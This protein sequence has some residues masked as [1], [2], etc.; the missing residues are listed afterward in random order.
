MNDHSDA[1]PVNENTKREGETPAPDAPKAPDAAEHAATESAAPPS[2]PSQGSAPAPEAATAPPAASSTPPAEAPP[3]QAIP[4]PESMETAVSKEV[5]TDAAAAMAGAMSGTDLGPDVDP[6]KL[7]PGQQ[8]TGTIVGVEGED[9]FLQFGPKVQGIVPRSQFGKKE[10]V[11]K[12]RRVDTTVEKYD[13]SSGLLMVARVGATQRATW[14][15][16]QPGMIVEGRVTGVVKGGLEIDLKGIRAFMPG[17][18]TDTHPMKDISVLLNENIRGEVIEVDRRGKNVILSRRKLMAKEQKEARK[19][20]KTELEVGQKRKGV[21]KRITDFGAFVDIGGIDGLLHISDLSWSMVDKV[22][23]VVKE[24]QEVEVIVLKL[25]EKKER[26]SLGL[27]QAQPSPWDDAPDKYPVGTSLKVR[28]LRLAKFGAFAELE[29]GLEGL[30]PISELSWNRV[31]TAKEVVG[32]GDMVDAVVIRCEPQKQRLALSVKQ[33]TPDPWQ[34]VLESFEPQALVKGK[35]T[36]LTDFGAFVEIAPG[37]EGLVHISEMSKDR[38]RSAGDVVK[39][40]QE[41][42]TRVLGVDAENRRISLSIKQVAEPDPEA[43]AAEAAEPHKPKKRKKP[44]R[45]GL[46]SNWEWQG[47][48]ISSLPSGD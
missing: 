14:T 17:S 25:D 10:S 6:D 37:V 31:N 24:E 48:D 1:A 39:E 38:V 29:P 45:G 33:A 11:D 18:H 23:D 4:T 32:E 46:S 35:V 12:G 20:L 13:E 26:I 40:G 44:L 36:R 42:E 7:E 21:V 30:I 22:T 9:V 5:A 15:N 3:T 47:L 43:P 19:Q 8:I 34:S 2:A 28:V 27:K 41:I 16:L